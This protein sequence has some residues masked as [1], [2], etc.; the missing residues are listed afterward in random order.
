MREQFKEAAMIAAMQALISNNYSSAK[1]VARRAQ[2]Y[3]IEL[4]LVQ[5]G[6]IIFEEEE[7]D[8]FTE[9]VV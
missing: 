2:E 8:P 6:E 1:Y 9:Q 4:T 7:I 5:Y 3:A